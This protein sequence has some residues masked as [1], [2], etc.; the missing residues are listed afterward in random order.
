LEK[1]IDRL[2][3]NQWK[4]WISRKQ[5]WPIPSKLIH[6]P[7]RLGGVGLASFKQQ[8]VLSR[9]RFLIKMY[10]K[11]PETISEYEKYWCNVQ[12]KNISIE[13]TID[14]I[15]VQEINELWY[16]QTCEYIINKF[17]M[18]GKSL[19]WKDQ[20]K[21]SK[22]NSVGRKL[23]RFIWESRTGTLPTCKRLSLWKKININCQCGQ[24]D[25]IP[26]IVGCCPLNLGIYRKRHNLIRDTI[27][28]HLKKKNRSIKKEFSPF[29]N[30]RRFDLWIEENNNTSIIEVGVLW[31]NNLEE[32]EVKKGNEYLEHINLLREYT[33]NNYDLNTIIIG[34]LGGITKKSCT[35]IK[36]LKVWNKRKLLKRLQNISIYGSFWCW[37]ARCR[38]YGR[39]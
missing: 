28:Q 15:K 27:I 20:F 6:L 39:L 22:L 21:I 35:N 8:Y 26:H 18:G 23:Y 13:T 33:N 14:N 29:I 12:L 17:K 31:N 34:Q 19:I 9:L 3:R 7:A 37:M 36:N 30:N 4:K 32:R 1:K 24:I 25:T 5:K 2:A 16:R 10:N 11:E 38:R